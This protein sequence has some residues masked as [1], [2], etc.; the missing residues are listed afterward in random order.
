MK[1]ECGCERFVCWAPISGSVPVL[2]DSEGNYSE[3]RF[4][5]EYIN[6][7]ICMDLPYGPYHCDDCGREYEELI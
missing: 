6:D 4:H 7:Y 1:C 5:S 2:V 3:D